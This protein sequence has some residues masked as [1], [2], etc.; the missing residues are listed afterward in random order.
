MSVVLNLPER[1]IL[2]EVQQVPRAFVTPL[3]LRLA[4]GGRRA[5]ADRG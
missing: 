5:D 1:A 2:D 4:D 3:S